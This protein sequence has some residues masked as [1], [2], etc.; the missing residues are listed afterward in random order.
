[1]K[2]VN[3]WKF[4]KCGREPGG[5]HVHDHGVCPAATETRLDGVHGGR[6]AGRACWV[7]AGTMCKGE[8]QGIFARKY[9]DCVICDF[10]DKVIAEERSEFL[11]AET[12]LNK[13]K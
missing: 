11:L 10:Y 8:V 6:N 12:L 2:K 1:M 13:L 4:K 7:V 5:T 3:C 9:L